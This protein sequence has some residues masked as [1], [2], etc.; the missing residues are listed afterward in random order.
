MKEKNGELWV[1]QANSLVEH[2]VRE[3]LCRL[4]MADRRLFSML[5]AKIDPFSND[6]ELPLMQISVAEYQ[7]IN[8]LS[9]GGGRA[10]RQLKK[11]V[12][13]LMT[14]VIEWPDPAVEGKWKMAQI[15]SEGE[16]ME[17]EGWMEVR[18]HSKLMPVLLGLKSA[19]SKYRLEM[20]GK[21]TSV[22]AWRLFEL[23]NSKLHQKSR[24]TAYGLEELRSKLG[25]EEGKLT[26]FANFRRKVLEV[27]MRQVSEHAAFEVALTLD[28]S[29]T[30]GGK[31]NRIIFSWTFKKVGPKLVDEM[32]DE[33]KLYEEFQT[34]ARPRKLDFWKWFCEY[35]SDLNPNKMDWAKIREDRLRT[36]LIN[37]EKDKLQ[38]KLD[39]S[40]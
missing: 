35:D 24:M 21:F 30:R 16:Y 23:L 26:T 29:G 18:L 8:G 11:S 4:S 7:R 17:G 10:F 40:S 19:F 5:I 14:T 6:S 22:Y 38:A 20:A 34:W 28:R 37:Y 36:G 9:V 1:V 25:V 33:E 15:L 31:V 27:A 39:L 3:S 13:T 12:K 32:S 2:R